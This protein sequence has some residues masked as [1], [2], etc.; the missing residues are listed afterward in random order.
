MVTISQ[1]SLLI[2]LLVE[3]PSNVLTEVKHG[4]YE[5]SGPI[6]YTIH[7]ETSGIKGNQRYF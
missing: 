4:V 5:A 3:F 7:L 2:L 6:P 1:I